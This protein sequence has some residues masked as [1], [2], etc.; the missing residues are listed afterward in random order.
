MKK[1]GV[2]KIETSFNIT[3]TGIVASGEII[4]GKVLT[5]CFI[6]LKIEEKETLVKIIGI[7]HGKPDSN[8]RLLWGLLLSFGDKA[9]EETLKTNRLQEQLVEILQY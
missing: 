4:E 2:F 3:Q 6:N 1:I 7:T 9:Q 5:G 8:G